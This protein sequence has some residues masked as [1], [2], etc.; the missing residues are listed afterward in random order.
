M[1]WDSP[2]APRPPGTR[3]L[4]HLPG[5]HC[6]HVFIRRIADETSPSHRQHAG[7]EHCFGGAAEEHLVHWSH[8]SPSAIPSRHHTAGC[9]GVAT[10]A[11][12]L[13]IFEDFPPEMNSAHN[14]GSRLAVG[15]AVALL[16][17]H[18]WHRHPR[19]HK[20]PCFCHVYQPFN[21]NTHVCPTHLTDVEASKRNTLEYSCQVESSGPL[22]MSDADQLA[23]LLSGDFFE[24]GGGSMRQAAAAHLKRYSI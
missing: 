13:H 23:S 2:A 11:P 9:G 3:L 14:T 6:S 17:K 4:W 24:H 22:R 21:W 8:I 1:S 10:E 20:S 18:T 16:V 15:T 5:S 7:Q 19:R 12:A